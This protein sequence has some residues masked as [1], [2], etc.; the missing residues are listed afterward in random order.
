MESFDEMGSAPLLQPPQ[1]LC[2]TRR[3]ICSTLAVCALIAFAIA[4]TSA[5]SAWKIAVNGDVP[6]GL[7]ENELEFI[8]SQLSNSLR[9]TGK[10]SNSTE[11]VQHLGGFCFGHNSPALHTPVGWIYLVIEGDWQNMNNLILALYDD[12]AV[13]WQSAQAGWDESSCNEKLR[14]ASL[15]MMPRAYHGKPGF[16]IS[17]LG[18]V[19]PRHWHLVLMKCGGPFSTE[20]DLLMPTEQHYSAW[21][22]RAL[23]QWGPSETWPAKCPKDIMGDVSRVV[24]KLRRY[25]S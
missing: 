14:Y 6:Y 17:I 22:V 15:R 12:E 23:S 25:V 1:T 9:L 7:P 19:M 3:I 21:G 8:E 16:L 5:L 2:T 4:G 13:H 10:L 18:H 24:W 11:T 20:E